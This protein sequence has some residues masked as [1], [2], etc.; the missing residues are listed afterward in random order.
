MIAQK[1]SDAAEV[2]ARDALIRGEGRALSIRNNRAEW[3]L[4]NYFVGRNLET[5]DRK[6][7]ER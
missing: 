3:L 1:Q 5:S 2:T 7:A 4:P 6:G